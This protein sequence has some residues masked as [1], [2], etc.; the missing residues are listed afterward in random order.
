[1]DYIGEGKPLQA[2]VA[3]DNIPDTN[4]WIRKN[5]AAHGETYDH[6]VRP[7]Y[8]TRGYSIVAGSELYDRTFYRDE[9]CHEDYTKLLIPRAVGYSAGLL[10]YFFRGQ[11]EAVN[12]ELIKDG[13]G[14]I[15]GTRFKIKNNTLDE[16]M[17]TPG[18]LVVS[19]EYNDTVYGVSNEVQLAENIETGSE[20]TIE[21]TFI[22]PDPGIPPSAQGVKYWLVYRGKLGNEDDAIAAKTLFPLAKV[23]GA[24]I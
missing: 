1:M 19:Y 22:F 11:I 4:F 3:E 12:P 15:T 2:V 7:S 17:E 10:N 8:H 6:F 9:A 14:N 18:K 23:W 16:A 5:N 20:S 21:Y 24:S 13:S